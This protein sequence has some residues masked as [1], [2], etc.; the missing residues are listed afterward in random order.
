M[1]I[2]TKGK[3]SYV[4]QAI[5]LLPLFA[6]GIIIMLLG[7]QWFT[8]AMHTQVEAELR[9]VAHNIVTLLDVA[10]PGDYELKGEVA[11]QLYKGEFDITSDYTLIDRVK[12]DTGMDITLFY[13]DTRIQTTITE[14]SGN[15][16]IGTGAPETIIQEVID[17]DESR[18][19][20]NI[21]INSGEY[22]AYYMP[23][24]NSDGSVVGMLFV[25]KPR[26]QV[27]EQV[28][29]SLYPLLITDIIVMIISAICVSLYM[30][31]FTSDLIKI[32]HFLGN[33]S[34]G[35]LNAE[36]HSSVSKRND[37]LG[38]I[39]RSA[40]A[41]QRSLRQMVE[42]DALTELYNRRSGDRKLKQ[43]IE[44]SM[45]QHTPFCVAL[46][47]VDFFKKVN[48]TYGHDC[49]DVVLQKVAA[50]FRT[51]MFHYGFVAR[52]GGEEF[53]L[54]F[55]HTNLEESH[56]ILEALREDISSME[57]KYQD[58]TIKITMTF[59]LTAGFSNDIKE[60]ICSVD[61]KL[62]QG[63]ASGRNRIVL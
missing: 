47:D 3:L 15:R 24:H 7:T 50:K 54:V 5:N 17:A 56:R 37:E 8:N 6:F 62:Y 2:N 26:N 27:D 55:D 28:Q 51:H 29:Q 44:K 61:E 12:K 43:V 36:L 10:Y 41:M 49:G 18:F 39:G 59:G 52:W 57:T 60:L 11:Y 40:L 34:T 38:D 42:Q 33:I 53:L 32:H 21:I 45:K 23:L 20:E 22:F 14:S 63:K 19:Y 16:I 46:G 4:L 25:G 9:N 35:N 1:S 58:Q 30:K 48:D 31:G 13:Q